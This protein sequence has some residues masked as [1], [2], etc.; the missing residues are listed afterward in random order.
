MQL[1]MLGSMEQLRGLANISFLIQNV[2]WMARCSVG[3]VTLWLAGLYL[4]PWGMRV[5]ARGWYRSIRLGRSWR[6]NVP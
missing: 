2:S 1:V 6:N 4:L 5:S 3:R